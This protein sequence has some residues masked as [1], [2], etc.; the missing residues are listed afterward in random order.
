MWNGRLE[1]NA[2]FY[3]NVNLPLM[4]KDENCQL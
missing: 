2:I 1:Y 4:D 3:S